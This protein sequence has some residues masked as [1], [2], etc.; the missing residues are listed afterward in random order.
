V[1]Q[2][3][4]LYLNRGNKVLAI[5]EI[6]S[7]G[8]SGTVADPRLIFAAA[9]KL[10]ASSLILC[11]NH[12]SG[13]LSPSEADKI[14]TEKISRAGKLLDVQVIDHI[15]LSSEGYFSFIDQGLL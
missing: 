10:N 3:K 9:L 7:G 2:F 4:V 14:L 5:I 12:P 13:N 11:H 8:I 15:I 6:S 1:E